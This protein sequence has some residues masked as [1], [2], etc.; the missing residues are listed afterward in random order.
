MRQPQEFPANE[1]VPKK[2]WDYA[3]RTDITLGSGPAIHGSGPDFGQSRVATSIMQAALVDLEDLRGNTDGIHG[4]SAG[5][6][7]RRWFRV[8]RFPTDGN[9]DPVTCTPAPAGRA[10]AL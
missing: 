7:G 8:R 1:E 9:K 5:V 2:N 6:C 10:P 3:P 4:A